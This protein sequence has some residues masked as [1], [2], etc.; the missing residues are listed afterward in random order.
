MRKRK[1]IFLQERFCQKLPLNDDNNWAYEQKIL[2]QGQE[3]FTIDLPEQL[4]IKGNT[5]FEG[6]FT[7]ENFK[8]PKVLTA[9]SSSELEI[10]GNTFL[11]WIPGFT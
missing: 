4:W 9:I 3:D 7:L 2:L 11:R 1:Y 5:D 8:V 6:Y 10:K